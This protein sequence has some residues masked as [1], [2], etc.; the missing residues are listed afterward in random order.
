MN[1]FTEI[2]LL[3]F[4]RIEAAMRNPVFLFMGV[5]MPLIYLVLFAP[6][7]NA[8]LKWLTWLSKCAYPIC[9]RDVADHRILNR[10]FYRIS[11]D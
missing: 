6:L 9:P 4:R 2:R 7:L 10:H 3:T 1:L 5:F 8:C 11:D